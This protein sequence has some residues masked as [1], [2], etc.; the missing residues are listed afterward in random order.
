MEDASKSFTAQLI[1]VESE[2]ANATHRLEKMFTSGNAASLKG[3]TKEQQPSS[4]SSAV[5]N[6][7]KLI[8][9]LT[10]L[11]MSLNTLKKDCEMIQNKRTSIVQSTLQ[12]QQENVTNVR[13]VP[14]RSC[15]V[16]NRYT[17]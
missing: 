12:L 9:R 5:V 15:A 4:T 16:I 17:L 8:R 3:G 13:K 6:P 11:E 7:I 1:L 14:F 10:A 2:I